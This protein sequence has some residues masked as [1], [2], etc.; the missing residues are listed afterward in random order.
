MF[1]DQI[2]RLLELYSGDR[3]SNYL[4][5]IIVRRLFFFAFCI[6]VQQVSL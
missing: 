3:M 1:A 4:L 6:L 2:E 5:L